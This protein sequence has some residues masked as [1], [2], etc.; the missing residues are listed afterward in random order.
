MSIFLHDHSDFKAL[1]EIVASEQG[2]KDPYLVEKDYWIMHC[3]WGLTETGLK[4]ELKGGTSL[5]KGYQCINRFSEDIDIK[6]NQHPDYKDMIYSGKNQD[7]EKHIESRKKYFN[8]IR[9]FLDGKIP[10]LTSVIRDNNFDDEDFRSGGVRLIYKSHFG[11]PTGGLK[12]GVLLEIGF[13]TTT[14]NKPLDI[15]SWALKKAQSTSGVDVRDN[16]AKGVICYE[17]KHTFVEKLQ[18][19]VKKFK[20]YKDGKKGKGNLPENFIR[21]YYDLYQLIDRED[22]QQFIGTPQY[23]EFKKIRF[24]SLDSKVSNSEAL[25]LSNEADRKIFEKEY[26]R[27]ADLYYKG[28]PSLDEMLIRFAKDLDRL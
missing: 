16:S 25:K 11:I 15:S 13:D 19:V 6:I 23:I 12:E 14:P 5:S 24:K 18:A 17:P 20:Q 27:S 26:N 3:L 22:V 28:R 7:E 10:G 4:F 9:D 21:H 8:W 2:I 1:M